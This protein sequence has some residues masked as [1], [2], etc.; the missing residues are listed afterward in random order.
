MLKYPQLRNFVVQLNIMRKNAPNE[1]VHR[2]VHCGR[3]HGYRD[4]VI[5]SFIC[6]MDFLSRFGSP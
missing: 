6:Y 5:E 4:F 1:L 3:K 2:G